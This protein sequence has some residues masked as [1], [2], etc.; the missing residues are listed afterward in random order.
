MCS[1]INAFTFQRHIRV[2]LLDYIPCHPR[3]WY[4]S[5]NKLVPKIMFGL[6]IT[7][8]AITGQHVLKVS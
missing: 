4:S 7:V 5:Y 1:I 8:R 3:R 2:I 6:K